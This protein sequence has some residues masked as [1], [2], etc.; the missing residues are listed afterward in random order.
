MYLDVYT[1]Y[2]TL[3]AFDWWTMSEIIPDDY[4]TVQ[5]VIYAL[6]STSPSCDMSYSLVH[7]GAVGNIFYCVDKVLSKHCR[8][9]EKCLLCVC[10]LPLQCGQVNAEVHMEIVNAFGI[11][12]KEYFHN[13]WTCLCCNNQIIV[14]KGHAAVMKPP[15]HLWGMNCFLRA[16]M[17]R[18]HVWLYTKSTLIRAFKAY[19][20]TVK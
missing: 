19:V 20:V 9:K 8:H 17:G 14:T 3:S 18:L 6:Q 11:V 15:V 7:C 2:V 12:I 10:G 16:E 5:S 1:K 13:S 4:A